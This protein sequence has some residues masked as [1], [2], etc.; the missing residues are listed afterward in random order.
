[1]QMPQY[2]RGV[3]TPLTVHRHPYPTRFHGGIWTRPV[4]GFPFV[5][6]VQDVFKPDDFYGSQRYPDRGA[7]SGR[8]LGALGGLVGEGDGIF[9]PG[10][11]GGGIF[12]GNLAGVSDWFPWGTDEAEIK[13]GASYPWGSYSEDTKKLQQTTNVALK[14][15]G[16]CPISEDGKLGPGTCGARKT[17]Q[18]HIPGMQWPATCQSFS[19]P[20]KCPSGAT[21]PLLSTGPGPAIA[22]SPKFMSSTMDNRSLAF[23]VGAGVAAAAVVYLA[24]KRKK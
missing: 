9:R 3:P 2:P 7:P 1:M 21:D 18:A 5:H 17:L 6:S 15:H 19:T 14:Q 13:A 16:Y 11:Y 4:F 8:P 12:D 10:G 20:S 24:K 23:L 22:P